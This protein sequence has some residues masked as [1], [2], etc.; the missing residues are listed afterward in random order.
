MIIYI[1]PLVP[2]IIGIF[3]VVSALT[4]AVAEHITTIH[5]ILAILFLLGFLCVFV[6]IVRDGVPG[7][8][9][10]CGAVLTVVSCIV[11]MVGLD[12]LMSILSSVENS[13]F[14]LFEFGI[15]AV[16][17]GAILLLIV[18]GSIVLCYHVAGL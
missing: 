8:R 15:P 10:T 6:Q 4:G 16:I 9:R 17:G 5:T 11:S 18:F 14:V 1:V 2:L 7:V 12:Q 3:L 13:L